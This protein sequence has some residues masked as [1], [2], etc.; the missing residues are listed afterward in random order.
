[1]FN[2]KIIFLILLTAASAIV[3]LITHNHSNADLRARAEI[4]RQLSQQL[5]E[6]QAVQHRMSNQL[7]GI[8]VPSQASHSAEI[9]KLRAEAEALQKQTNELA[10]QSQFHP[11][12]KSKHPVSKPDNHSP[13]YWQ[14][15]QQAAGTKSIDAL[16][17][18]SAMLDYAEDHHNQYPSSL[19]QIAPYLAKEN[20]TLSGTNQFE[21]VFQ[22]SSDQLNGIPWNSIAVVRETQTWLTP[23]GRPARVYGMIAGSGQIVNSDDNF[24]SWEAEHVI[25]PPNSAR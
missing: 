9:A 20:R 3:S 14:Q 6:L 10:K 1:M 21:I 13:E 22:G 2:F 23:D 11:A 18:A 25:S 15:F 5:I 4:L 24:Q 12:L 8:A 17:L 19:D 7:A 16:Y